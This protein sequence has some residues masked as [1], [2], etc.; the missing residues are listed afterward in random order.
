MG[1]N[2][3]NVMSKLFGFLSKPYMVIVITNPALMYLLWFL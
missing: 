2:Q 1:I 3:L